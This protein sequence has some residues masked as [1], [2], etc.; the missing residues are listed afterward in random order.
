MSSLYG[1]GYKEFNSTI[2][3]Q[4]TERFKAFT[5]GMTKSDNPG[6]QVGIA[7]AFASGMGQTPLAKPETARDY[8]KTFLPYISTFYT[9]FGHSDKQESS[10]SA[11]RDVYMSSTR[12]DTATNSNIT[13]TL[14]Y[15]NE[16]NTY[17]SDSTEIPMEMSGLSGEPEE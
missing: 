13:E 16:V 1:C 12:S 3:Q 9:M 7:M 11:G 4:N 10:I 6:A 8:L 2:A 17:R 14:G 15:D 5:E